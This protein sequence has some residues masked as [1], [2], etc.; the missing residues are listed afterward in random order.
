MFRNLLLAAGAALVMTSPAPAQEATLK[1]AYGAWEVRCDAQSRCF[2]TQLHVSAQNT[3]DVIFTVF[4]PK[5]ASDPNNPLP[6]AVAEIAAP[7]GI[8]L[9]D[10]LGV[11][12]DSGQA[13]G[14]PFE[15]CVEA[16]CIVRAPISPEMLADL[17]RGGQATVVLNRQPGVPY[18]ATF[19]LSGFTSAFDSL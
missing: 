4:K 12:V 7:L 5:G 3:P 13:R 14:A 1:A 8:Y 11:R 9:P 17:K 19:S 16:G 15:R 2:M 10:G 6:V 18:E